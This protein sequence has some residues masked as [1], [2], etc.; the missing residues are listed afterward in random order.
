M[1]CHYN[2]PPGVCACDIPDPDFYGDWRDC[3]GSYHMARAMLFSTEFPIGGGRALEH[4][5]P[6][7]ALG[8][9]SD[10]RREPEEDNNE[11]I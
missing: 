11:E 3:W 2:M 8:K 7:P 9:A 10:P 4:V 5:I 1:D 6:H